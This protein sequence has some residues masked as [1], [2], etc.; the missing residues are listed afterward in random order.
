MLLKLVYNNKN[1]EKVK[2]TIGHSHEQ[3]QD[4]EEMAEDDSLLTRA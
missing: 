4:I 3:Q 2:S 1:H